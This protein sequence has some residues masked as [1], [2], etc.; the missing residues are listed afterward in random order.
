MEEDTIRLT[1]TESIEKGID[2]LMSEM[3]QAGISTKGDFLIRNGIMY[4]G[5]EEN[6][7]YWVSPYGKVIGPSGKEIVLA[8]HNTGYLKVHLREKKAFA[9]RVVLSAYF[10]NEI[11][12]GLVVNHKDLDKKNNHLDNLEWVT[13]LGNSN[14]YRANDYYKNRIFVDMTERVESAENFTKEEVLKILEELKAK[15]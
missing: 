12:P 13:H 9:H 8:E 11:D 3:R 5:V 15:Y 7:G 1:P 2:Y 10:P 4:K 6:P 14:H